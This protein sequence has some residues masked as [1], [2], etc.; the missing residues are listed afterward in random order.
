MQHLIHFDYHYLL[1]ATLTS[2]LYK[3][4]PLQHASCALPLHFVFPV[5]KWGAKM[6]QKMQKIYLRT[7]CKSFENLLF[8]QFPIILMVKKAVLQKCSLW[9]T[10]A[11]VFSSEFAAYFQNIFLQ[12]HLWMAASMVTSRK[13]NIKIEKWAYINSDKSGHVFAE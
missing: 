11:W 2:P 8:H 6:P 9:S 12:E 4:Q 7:P 3:W 1:V 13:C 5:W 10:S